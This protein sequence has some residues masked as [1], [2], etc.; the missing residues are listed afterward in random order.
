M[1]ATPVII[2]V[3]L[4]GTT[5]PERNPHV[6]IS[7]DELIAEGLA[8][9][10]A[11]ASIVH[12][13]IANMRVPAAEAA[14]EYRATFEPWL[15]ADPD[16]LALP[17]LGWGATMVEKLGHV[18][19]LAEAGV[20]RLGFIDP[21][22]MILGKAGA[23]GLPDP[24]SFVYVNTFADM[25]VAIEQCNRHGLGMHFAIFEPGFLRN[26]LSYWRYDRLTPGSFVKFYFGGPGGYFAIGDSVSFGLP[27]TEKALDAYL[28][29]LELAGC[30]LPWFSAVVG[31][32]LVRTPIAGLTLER[33]GHLRVGH[34][35]HAGDRTPP[36]RE[37]VAEVAA[38]AADMGRPVATPAQAAEILGLPAR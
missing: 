35:D 32:D 36:N 16:V 12:C 13:H 30:D 21:G 4:N 28:E 23:D 10:E 26:V 33:G 11:G 37:L 25:E 1:D 5:T 34:E 17:T 24:D 2:E 27:P 38:L 8:C 15:A 22:S 3:A 9:I 6:P 18:A 29:M 19:L 31:G 20:L 7:R 14:D